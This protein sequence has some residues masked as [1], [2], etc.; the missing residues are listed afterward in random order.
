MRVLADGLALGRFKTTVESPVGD[1][2]ITVLRAD[3]AK[4][5]MVLLSIDQLEMSNGLAA[6]E[7]GE[8]FGLTAV[9]NA[10]MFATD[11]RTHVGYMSCGGHV[12]S[13]RWNDY[14]SVA[15]FAPRDTGLR[16][17][18]IFDL[19]EVA[20]D[21]IASRYDCVVQNLRL[22]KRTGE[23]RWSPQEKKWSEAALAEDADGNILF[24]F[25]RS[26]YSM[27]Q[28]N[29]MLMVLPI[30]LVC[31]QHLEGG[32]EAQLFL[33]LDADTLDL[34][35]TY[36]TGFKEDGQNRTAWPIPNVLGL[37]PRAADRPSP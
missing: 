33:K 15:A 10:G 37:R 11:Y 14:L 17:F 8:R 23:N 29:E 35:G 2:I 12:N 32:P 5:E 21:S 13:S 1:S 27:H 31:A 28:L 25:S 9:I 20:H 30:N 3:P 34:W 36:E 22:I 7:W 18:R 6:R 24:V 4:W 26:P 16:L 19:D